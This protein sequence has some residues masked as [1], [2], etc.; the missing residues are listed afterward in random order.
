MDKVILFKMIGLVMLVIG[1]FMFIAGFLFDSKFFKGTGFA[2]VIIAGA[3]IY[4]SIS[5]TP[6]DKISADEKRAMD[7]PAQPKVPLKK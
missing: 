2:A 4:Y 3:L 7:E 5:V 6:V 1:V